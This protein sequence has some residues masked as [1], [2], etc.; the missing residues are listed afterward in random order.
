MRSKLVSGLAVLAVVAAC[1]GGSEPGPSWVY[2]PTVAPP[3]GSAAASPTV[4]EGSA[5]PAP[6]AA[7]T[8]AGEGTQV[9]IGTD[10]G[11]ALLFDP[12]TASVAGG[13]T[14]QVTFENISTVPH[15][16][17]FQDP[18]DAATETVVAPGASETIEFEAPAPGDYAFV[19]TLHPGMDGTL[20]VQG[21]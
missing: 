19:C 11:V 16:L 1:S 7:S 14:V 17:T 8:P 13:G 12:E 6:S 5:P 20:T 21:P 2:G 10:T 18:I 3:A 4:T 9:T 15:N